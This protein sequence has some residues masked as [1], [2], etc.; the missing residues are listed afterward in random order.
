MGADEDGKWKRRKYIGETYMERMWGK[1]QLG[2]CD[3]CLRNSIRYI[4]KESSVSG[5]K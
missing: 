4:F 5:K 1:G 2:I 3:I